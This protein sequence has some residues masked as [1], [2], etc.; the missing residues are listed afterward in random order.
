MSSN[1]LHIEDFTVAHY[2]ELLALAKAR[3]LFVGYQEIE[4][5]H[6]FVLWRHDCDFS[7]N[8]SLR[9]AEIEHE[10]GVKATYFV[11]PHSEFYNPLESSQARLVTG[12]ASLGH[13]IGLHFDAAYYDVQSEAEL[14]QLVAKEAAWLYGWFGIKV[15]AF[16]FHNPTP[17]MLSC[18]RERYGDLINCYSRIFK[19][20]VRYCSDS[21]GYWR[22]Q[23]LYDALKD[24]AN[25]YLQVL[26]H[27]AWWQE[28]PLHPRERVFRSVYGR[29][30]ATMALYDEFLRVHGRNN[31]AGPSENLR[32]IRQRDPEVFEICDYL[33][34][35]GRYDSLFAELW[36]LHQ[37]QLYTMCRSLLVDEWSIKEDDVAE[38]MNGF[39]RINETDQLFAK[40]Y[41]RPC[42]VCAG[43][44]DESYLHWKS[45][46]ERIARGELVS[47]E[48]LIEGSVFLC[49]LIEAVDAWHATSAERLEQIVQDAGQRRDS[50]EAFMDRWTLLVQSFTSQASH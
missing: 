12:I 42:T 1:S 39:A 45:I 19:Q 36:R 35:T 23:R 44:S 18:E 38:F 26:T 43:V 14:D 31:L 47:S 8:R 48:Q 4:F 7:L 6:P 11:N 29:A 16:S 27:D 3:Y 32:F 41:E 2:R 40:V 22:F 13:D 17:F 15:A 28:A 34:N 46:S 49:R 33:W 37:R 5:G 9:L 10:Q 21:N 24:P 20:K 30:N 25:D 50:R